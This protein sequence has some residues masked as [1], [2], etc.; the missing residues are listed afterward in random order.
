MTIVLQ[1][2]IPSR[3]T[4]NHPQKGINKTTA[5]KPVEAT[6]DTSNTATKPSVKKEK[7]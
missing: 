6:A 7:K 4:T 3:E 5:E 1:K 2:I